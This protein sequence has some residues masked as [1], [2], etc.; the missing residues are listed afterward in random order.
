LVMK[1]TA[2]LLEGHLVLAVL[3]AIIATLPQLQRVRLHRLD[4]PLVDVTFVFKDGP[5]GLEHRPRLPVYLKAARTT[6]TDEHLLASRTEE[7]LDLPFLTH[8]LLANPLD[9]P[10]RARI[11]LLPIAISIDGAELVPVS[12]EIDDGS[13][14]LAGECAQE[15]S[16]RLQIA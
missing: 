9:D 5:V 15:P 7:R 1:Q 10:V 14:G 6:T 8:R 12:P 11:V 3:S 2:S 13:V 4:A 16:G